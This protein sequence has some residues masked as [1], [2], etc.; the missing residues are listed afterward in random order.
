MRD[1]NSWEANTNQFRVIILEDDDICPECNGTGYCTA[2]VNNMPEV[3]TILVIG[4]II[5][6]IVL[7]ILE[8]FG[9]ALW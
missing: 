9:V 6:N 5:L 8:Y 4:F 1:G 3:A 2:W 7:K